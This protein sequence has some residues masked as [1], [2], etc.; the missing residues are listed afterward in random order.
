M[1]NKRWFGL[2]WVV[3]LGTGLYF[4]YQAWQRMP[5]ATVFVEWTT[6]SELDTAGFNLYRSDAP[7]GVFT[8]VNQTLI[9]SSPDPLTGGS[10]SYT[11]Y[12]VQPGQTYYYELEDVELDGN[13][14][15]HGPI[16]VRAQS[17][18]LAE[19]MLAIIFT[20]MALAGFFVTRLNRKSH[21][22]SLV[23]ERDQEANAG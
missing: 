20:G 21:R 16:E 2:L 18:G 15:R 17:G 12:A 7:D 19:M 11:D 14:S 22:N 9:P 3:C 6:A 5:T 10:Y 1:I 23:N 8:Q 13:S 4:A